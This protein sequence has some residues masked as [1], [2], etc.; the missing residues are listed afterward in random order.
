MLITGNSEAIHLKQSYKDVLCDVSLNLNVL[1]PFIWNT[2]RITET[3]PTADPGGLSDKPFRA[4]IESPPLVYSDGAVERMRVVRV[5]ESPW[6]SWASPAFPAF[7]AYPAL[8]YPKSFTRSALRTPDS[9]L[10]TTDYGFVP[11]PHLL[12]R[13]HAN[14]LW[15]D[16]TQLLLVLVFMVFVLTLYYYVRV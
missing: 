12:T 11:D 5:R 15:P 8:A 6:A 1:S 4:Q 16:T 2:K 7:P 10:P 13:N 3:K 14:P 9:R